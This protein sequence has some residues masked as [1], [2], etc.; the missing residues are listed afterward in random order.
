VEV[1]N[2]SLGYRHII[3]LPVLNVAIL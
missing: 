2:G 3:S 1:A